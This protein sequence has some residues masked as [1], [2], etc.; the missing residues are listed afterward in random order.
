MFPRTSVNGRYAENFR[1]M[2]AALKKGLVCDIVKEVKVV[3]KRL[4]NVLVKKLLLFG[5]SETSETVD[6]E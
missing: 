6:H 2:N 3:M 4:K 1:P 5:D